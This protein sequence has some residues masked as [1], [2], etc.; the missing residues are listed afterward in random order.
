MQLLDVAFI[1]A[2]MLAFVA[3][4]FFG[5]QLA[6]ATDRTEVRARMAVTAGFVFLNAAE[7]ALH[8]V[9][10]LDMALL[11]TAV[12]LLVAGIYIGRSP[13]KLPNSLP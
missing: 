5:H 13:R 1:V 7:L 6:T 2:G 11:G 4:I 3:C 12:A 8:R 10:W 9:P